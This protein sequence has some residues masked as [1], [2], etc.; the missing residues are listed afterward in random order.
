MCS[1][2]LGSAWLTGSP[3]PAASYHLPGPEESLGCRLVNPDEPRTSQT[4]TSP[5]SP[6]Q[7]AAPAPAASHPLNF[8]HCSYKA[9]TPLVTCKVP[10]HPLVLD[11]A[12]QG[13]SGPHLLPGLREGQEGVLGSYRV[14]HPVVRTLQGCPAAAPVA[15][16]RGTRAAMRGYGELEAQTHS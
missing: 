6:L 11:A 3:S 10:T 5:C 16:A 15:Q 1:W 12:Q 7:Q 8:L 14:P 2:A 13:W 4:K 9:E